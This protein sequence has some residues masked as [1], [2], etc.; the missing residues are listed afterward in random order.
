MKG[1]GVLVF[2]EPAA[3]TPELCLRHCR[4]MIFTSNLSV[5]GDWIVGSRALHRQ[6]VARVAEKAYKVKL[7]AKLDELLNALNKE[8]KAARSR[9]LMER[10]LTQFRSHLKPIRETFG[11]MRAVRH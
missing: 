8:D 4:L 7:A 10:G 5:V 2:S 6:T 9:L 3:A 11:D 1:R